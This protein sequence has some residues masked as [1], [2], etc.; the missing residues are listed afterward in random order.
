MRD[1]Q[2]IN[3]PTRPG[4]RRALRILAAL[5]SVPLTIGTVRAIA[6]KAERHS[7]RGEVLGALSSLD[8]WHADA[9]FAR[10]T[11]AKSVREIERLEKIFS[12]YRADSEISRLNAVGK[13]I[14]PSRELLKLVEE[15]RRLSE[16]S[17]GAF[18]ISVQPLWKLYETQFWTARGAV[19]DFTAR[20]QEMAHALV[21]YRAIDTGAAS[22][23]FAKGNM[24]IT[25]NSMAQGFVTD[26]VTDILRN[27]GFE[28][29][30]VDLGEFRTI[31]RHPE[32]RPWRFGLHQESTQ[33][34][35]MPDIDIEDMALAVSRG[36]GTVFEP[37]GQHHHIFDPRTGESAS[38]LLQAAVIAPSAA[39]ADGLATAICAAGEESAPVLLSA[40]PNARAIITRTNGGITTATAHGLSFV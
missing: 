36:S 3:T 19:T 38:R 28:S 39:A 12:L 25:L 23:A 37:S 8:I 30:V 4:R 14:A 20:A 32:G 26:R 2:E 24:A 5:A 34:G 15:G 21:D 16:L 11:I 18:D 40:Y 27:E 22:I 7:W 6:P 31:G 9:G 33:N 1:A 29:A 17:G 10:A 35:A 13:I